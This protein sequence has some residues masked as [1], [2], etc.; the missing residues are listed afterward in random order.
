MLAF[1]TTPH[2]RKYT[3]DLLFVARTYWQKGNSLL[4]EDE[5]DMKAAERENDEL[6]PSV[7][8]PRLPSTWQVTLEG[9]DNP[10]YMAL[11]DL[12]ILGVGDGGRWQ[13]LSKCMLVTCHNGRC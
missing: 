3:R 11:R 4:V 6:L 1:S 7:S 10:Q 9:N 8:K 12:S 13:L 2:T 5:S